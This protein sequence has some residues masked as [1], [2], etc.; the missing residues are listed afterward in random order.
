MYVTMSI[1]CLDEVVRLEREQ[2]D[3]G[4]NGLPGRSI[5]SAVLGDR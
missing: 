4:V 1:C 2:F 3:S 5:G